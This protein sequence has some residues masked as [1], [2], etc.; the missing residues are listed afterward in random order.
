[1]SRLMRMIGQNCAHHEACLRLFADWVKDAGITSGV[2][3]LRLGAALHALVQA[4]DRATSERPLGY[5]S[6]EISD[7]LEGAKLTSATLA[8]WSSARCWTRG[9]SRTLGQLGSSH[10]G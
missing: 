8:W 5:M 10:I 1:M 7:D 6:M 2:L 3:P 9:F 4:G